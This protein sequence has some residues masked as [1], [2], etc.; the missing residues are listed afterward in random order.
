MSERP[1]DGSDGPEAV[2]PVML[3]VLSNRGRDATLLS[4]DQERLL[5]DWVAGRLAP[6]QAERAAALAKQNT[7]AAERLLERRLLEAA[8]QSPTVPQDL[9][10]RVLK[11]APLSRIS[12]AAGWWRSLGRWRWQGLAGAVVLAG[13]VA[14]VGVPLWQQTMQGGESMQVAMVT[15]NDRNPLFEPSDLR[16]RGPGP[17]PGPVVEQR[18][19]DAEVPTSILKGLLA[20]AASPRSAASR[21]IEPYLSMSGDGRPAHVIVDSALKAKIDASADGERMLVRIYDLED[22]RAADIRPLVGQLPKGR[23]IYLLTLKP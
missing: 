13:V 1:P 23:R 6:E 7:L 14:V 11:A 19:H 8:R 20:A 22:P 21:E 12:A 4:S 2:D 17:Q 15:I 3:A 10:E 16:M 5:D 18:F 9:E